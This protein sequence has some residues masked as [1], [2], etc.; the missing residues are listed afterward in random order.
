M[1]ISARTTF[2]PMR[3]SGSEEGVTVPLSGLE[4]SGPVFAYDWVTHSGEL[5]PDGGSLRMKF[6]DGWD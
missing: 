2:L 5:L 1:A 4:I 3:R 6:T